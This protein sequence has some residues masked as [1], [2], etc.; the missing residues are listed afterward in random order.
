MRNPFFQGK[1]QARPF[2]KAWTLQANAILKKI[3][4]SFP[5]PSDCP[6]NEL[7]ITNLKSEIK[8]CNF[9]QSAVISLYEQMPCLN[10]KYV[11]TSFRGHDSPT[12][13]AWLAL[14]LGEQDTEMQ[15]AWCWPRPPCWE[16]N[17]CPSPT[18]RGGPVPFIPL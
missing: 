5:W 4:F 18:A 8:H 2:C 14:S 3:R 12:G 6:L 13:S 16:L 15:P 11:S 17:C 10:F 9:Y 7:K 1:K